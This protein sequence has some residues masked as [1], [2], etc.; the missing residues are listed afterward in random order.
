MGNA[1]ERATPAS[2]VVRVSAELSF[3]LR[4]RLAPAA[5]TCLAF[6]TS[7]SHECSIGNC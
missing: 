3:D 7:A 6:G 5:P 2:R 1:V 4:G